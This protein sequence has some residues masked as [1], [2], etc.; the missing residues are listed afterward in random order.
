[1]RVDLKKRE[2]TITGDEVA[3]MVN[4]WLM[5]RGVTIDPNGDLMCEAE[6]VTIK[7][8]KTAD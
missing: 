8:N 5:D 4:K 2:V 7:Y 1:M 6:E 3:Q